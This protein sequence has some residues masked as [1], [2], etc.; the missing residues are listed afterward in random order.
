[1]AEY[2]QIPLRR[3]ISA[4]SPGWPGRL[5]PSS[6]GSAGLKKKIPIGRDIAYWA[7]EIDGP[8]AGLLAV[9]V[10]TVCPP[11][12]AQSGLITTD[13][14]LTT[15]SGAA[16]LCSLRWLRRPTRARSIRF[17]SAAGFGGSVEIFGLGIPAFYLVFHACLP[18]RIYTGQWSARSGSAAAV[19]LRF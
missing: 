19:S 16:V 18:H 7:A 2:R 15:F 6:R 1:M 8:S 4:A 10:F 5:A 12:L 11:V 3:S 14:A 9:F 17:W 13:M